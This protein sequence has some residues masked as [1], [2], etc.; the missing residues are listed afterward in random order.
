MANRIPS[1]IIFGD[2]DIILQRG[3]LVSTISVTNQGNRVIRVS[4]HCDL[5]EVNPAL[6]LGLAREQLRHFRFNIP[7]NTVLSFLPGETRQVPV[8]IHRGG[9]VPGP[10]VNN[11]SNTSAEQTLSRETYARLYGPTSGDKVRL[12]DTD[13]W[14]MIEWDLTSGSRLSD[15]GNFYGDEASAGL[16]KGIRDSIMMSGRSAQQVPDAVI[17]NV[18]LIDHH[19]IRKADIAIRDGRIQAIGKAGNPDIQSNI[20]IP[21]GTSTKIVAGEGLIATPGGVDIHTDFS[22]PQQLADALM[23]GITTLFGGE[24]NEAI[25]PDIVSDILLHTDSLPLNLGIV[26]RGNHSGRIDEQVSLALM[27]EMTDFGVVSLDINAYAGV[28]LNALHSAMM[29]MQNNLGAAVCLSSD[30]LNERF[31]VDCLIW[32][33]EFFSAE[34]GITAISIDTAGGSIPDGITLA[35]SELIISSSY[36]SELPYTANSYTDIKSLYPYG[37]GTFGELYKH[38]NLLKAQTVLQHQGVLPVVTSG[39]NGERVAQMITRCWQSADLM[40]RMAA[41]LQEQGIADNFLIQRY[42]AK[43]TINPALCMGVADDVGSLDEGKLADIILWQPALFGVQCEMVIKSGIP[44][45]V[46][47]EYRSQPLDFYDDFGL[48]AASQSLVFIRDDGREDINRSMLT[49][50]LAKVSQQNSLKTDM[51]FNDVVK[52][53]T[54]NLETAKV[55]AMGEELGYDEYQTL[56]L[57][58]NFSLF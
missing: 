20:T 51:I 8:T 5:A 2:G 23:S 19:G 40:K 47:E 4:S 33:S 35:D 44:I 15:Q 12:G 34:T 14:F 46:N 52:E 55:A 7:A 29:S 32:H 11:I 38:A 27:D 39:E 25:A 1:E 57:A 41:P 10:G 18:I 22:K 37:S 53:I 42:I 31:N 49:K 26:R 30:S 28:S 50:T 9:A 48:S 58:L 6:Y 54:V 43:Y 3:S 17:T 36:A 13:I 24:G 16:G 21:I 45:N 56:P